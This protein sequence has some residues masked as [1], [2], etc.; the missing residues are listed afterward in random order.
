MADNKN[1]KD[2]K[3]GFDISGSSTRPF[4]PLPPSAV[5]KKKETPKK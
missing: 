1:S 4:K 2:K 3:R 5:K